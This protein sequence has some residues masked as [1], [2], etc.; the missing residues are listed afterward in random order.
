M[1]CGNKLK[2]CLP[3]DEKMYDG[4]RTTSSRDASNTSVCQ[5]NLH[6]QRCN[7]C[8]SK[9]VKM[10]MIASPYYYLIASALARLQPR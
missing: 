6:Q 1:S 2:Q 7:I 5:S 10:G 4:A 8:S 3:V 9:E